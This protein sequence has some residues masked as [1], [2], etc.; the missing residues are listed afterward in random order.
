MKQ[1]YTAVVKQDANFANSRVRAPATHGG[2]TQS[3]T[4]VVL[5]RDMPRS[6]TISR[7]RSVA[8]SALLNQSGSNQLFHRAAFGRR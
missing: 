8:T 2:L 7:A 1:T 6:T 3:P 4:D 5:F